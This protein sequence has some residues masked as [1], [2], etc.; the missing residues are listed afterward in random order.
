MTALHRAVEARDVPT[1]QRLLDG[2]ADPNGR[3][4]AVHPPLNRAAQLGD[5]DAVRALLDAG[6]DPN[7]RGF[8]NQTPLF[9]AATGEGDTTAAVL[10]LLRAG[11]DPDARDRSA[12]TALTCAERVA[13][14]N[15]AR[16]LA[17]ATRGH[18]LE[19]TLAPQDAETPP[20]RGRL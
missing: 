12:E 7:A 6:A 2:G 14:P 17:A 3:R 15:V 1:L 20:K 10:A 9:Y 16:L 8:W 5:V 13:H 11:A 18:L 4:R 19:N